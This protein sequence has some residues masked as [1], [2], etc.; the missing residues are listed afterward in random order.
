MDQDFG[1]F[2]HLDHG[3]GGL[4]ILGKIAV[5]VKIFSRKAKIRS[6]GAKM[7]RPKERL[8]LILAKI[9]WSCRNLIEN[10]AL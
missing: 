9:F 10:T 4:I 6:F 1:L 3:L 7:F 2:Q 5:L 8:S